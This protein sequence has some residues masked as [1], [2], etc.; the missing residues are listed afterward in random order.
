MDGETVTVDLLHRVV[1]AKHTDERLGALS[2]ESSIR[3]ESRQK[4]LE[5]KFGDAFGDVSNAML[6][7]ARSLPA[8]GLAERPTPCTSNSGRKFL[9]AK[10]EGAFPASWT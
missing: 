8:S 4:Y 9:P 1:P 7:S 5:G 6:G 2:G 3:P 10:K